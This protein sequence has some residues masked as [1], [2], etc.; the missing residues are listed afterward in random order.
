MVNNRFEAR[1]FS[2]TSLVGVTQ[3]GTARQ[4]FFIDRGTPI[5]TYPGSSV[6]YDVFKAVKAYNATDASISGGLHF[7]TNLAAT[8]LLNAPTIVQ[9][10][11][12]VSFATARTIG[13]FAKVTPGGAYVV[14]SETDPVGGKGR[15]VVNCY[16]SNFALLTNLS[17]TY[18]DLLKSLAGATYLYTG[19]YGGGYTDGLDNNELLFQISSA[20]HY[21]RVNIAG[22]SAAAW[23]QSIRLQQLSPSATPIRCFSGLDT[24]DAALFSGI[25]P[26]TGINGSYA[27]G[28]IVHNAVAAT[29][30]PSYWQCVTAGRLAPAWAISTAYV[31]GAVVLNDINKIYACTTAGTSAGAGGPTGIGTGIVDGTVVWDY[32]APLA[33]FLAGAN[34]P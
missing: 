9:R 26:G 18:P 23:L 6:S 7:G 27:R 32:I 1:V 5:S 8:P 29:G 14:S 22:G 3:T 16:D 17:A 31:V 34:L 12:S 11:N 30:Q 13:F 2:T 20:V 33:T 28:Q 25:A 15:I 21:V 4:N 24:D 19:F 10:R